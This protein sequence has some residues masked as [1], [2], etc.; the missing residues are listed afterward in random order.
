MEWLSLNAKAVIYCLIQKTVFSEYKMLLKMANIRYL[1]IFFT[2][3]CP[4]QT[5]TVFNTKS[6]QQYIYLYIIGCRLRMKLLIYFILGTPKNVNLMKIF[7]YCIT[8]N[9][10]YIYLC[11][12]FVKIILILFFLISMQAKTRRSNFIG[13]ENSATQWTTKKGR[14]RVGR[15]LSYMPKDQI[16]RRCRTPVQLLRY[17]MLCQVWRQGYPA[18]EQS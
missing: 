1:G 3:E 13:R 9:V 11:I 4:F 10:Y 2:W 6:L 8:N 17:Q 16:R 7:Y 12:S 18:F 5:P 15:N 14:R